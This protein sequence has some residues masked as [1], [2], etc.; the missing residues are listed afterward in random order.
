[1][2]PIAADTISP[3]KNEILKLNMKS[4]NKRLFHTDL[5]LLHCTEF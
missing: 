1:M 3:V 5:I 2:D 4:I